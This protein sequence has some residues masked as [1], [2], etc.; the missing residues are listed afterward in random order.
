MKFRG[1]LSNGGNQYQ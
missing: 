1:M